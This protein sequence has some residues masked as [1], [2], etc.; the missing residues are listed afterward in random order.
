MGQVG[1]VGRVVLYIYT[2]N[3]IQEGGEIPAIHYLWN[4]PPRQIFTPAQLKKCVTQV[5]MMPICLS[6]SAF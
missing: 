2:K 5:G 3:C 1:R 4:C 6:G